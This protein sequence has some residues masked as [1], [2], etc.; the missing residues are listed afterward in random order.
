MQQIKQT[1]LKDVC[2]FLISYCVT[3]IIDSMCFKRHSYD[4]V[5]G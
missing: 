4:A 5:G 1:L 2:E 3:E